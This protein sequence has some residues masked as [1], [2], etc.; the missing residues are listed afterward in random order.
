MSSPIQ[1]KRDENPIEKAKIEVQ[2]QELKN[3]LFVGQAL[4]LW[5]PMKPQHFSS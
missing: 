5:L 4:L 1:I 2:L 3:N